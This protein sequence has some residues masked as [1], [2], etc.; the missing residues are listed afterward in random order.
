MAV[1]V[2]RAGAQGQGEEFAIEQGIASIDFG[3][4]R[5]LADFVHQS[6]L[7]DQ[8]T[9]T[10]TA[11]Q[12]WRFAHEIK[13]GDMIV[14]PRKQPKVIAVG[15]I[16][17]DYAYRPDLEGAHGPHTRPVDWT[18][19]DIPRANFDQDVLHSL[20]GL[21]TVFQP[22]A[23]NAEKRIERVS[24]A[25]LAGAPVGDTLSTA[26]LPSEPAVDVDM[27]EYVLDFIIQ[28]IRR[29]FSGTRLEYL[30]ARIL[31]A[32]GYT[33]L[34]TRPGPDGGVDVIAGSGKLGF[35][36]PRLC[37]QVKS[38]REPIDL[39]DYN[40]LQGNVRSF[41]A[42]HGLLVS[43]SDFKR[44]VRNENERSFFEIRLWGPGELAQRVREAYDSLPVDVQ[45]D[46]PLERGLLPRRTEDW[47]N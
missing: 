5:D 12:L 21:A 34:Q 27:D 44:S 35:G 18:V 20:G 32:E 4:R 40:R 13:D 33:A 22:R 25:Y 1:W 43:L 2:I 15:K 8:L 41:G 38:G 29:R 45:T 39:P 16:T 3:F 31:E 6:A 11:S 14:L 10:M 30:V 37:V 19:T 42:D 36:E 47:L 46:I 7:R 9:S 23:D 28:C 17:G 26:D 24:Q